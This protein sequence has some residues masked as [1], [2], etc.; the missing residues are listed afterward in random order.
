MSLIDNEDKYKVTHYDETTSNHP[1]FEAAVAE[2]AKRLEPWKEDT[3]TVRRQDWEPNE[4][5]G[6]YVFVVNDHGQE[7]DAESWIELL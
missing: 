3:D 5:N 1:T 4:E 7:T 2:A 6:C